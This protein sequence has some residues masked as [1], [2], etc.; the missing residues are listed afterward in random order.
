MD[1]EMTQDEKKPMEYTILGEWT[2]KD[3]LLY[4]YPEG[5]DHLLTI[6]PRAQETCLGV[7][8]F[9]GSGESVSTVDESI[10]YSPTQ[11]DHVEKITSSGK[12]WIPLN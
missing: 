8:Y 6:P 11:D 10:L 12:R 7:Q 2:E 4:E 1:V 3:V 5:I 9:S